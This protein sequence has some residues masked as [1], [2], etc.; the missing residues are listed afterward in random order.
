VTHQLMTLKTELPQICS[1]Q[2]LGFSNK[3]KLYQPT[4]IFHLLKYTANDHKLI[5]TISVP[6]ENFSLAELV[7]YNIFCCAIF[8][9]KQRSKT[10]HTLHPG[11]TPSPSSLP[12]LTPTIN[13]LVCLKMK[14]WPPKANSLFPLSFLFHCSIYSPEQRDNTPPIHSYLAVHPLHNNFH[15]CL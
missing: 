15:C 3:P 8:H 6:E 4:R 5:T 12:L 11:H 14:R 13:W 10:P 1:C 7:S 2:Q 9:P